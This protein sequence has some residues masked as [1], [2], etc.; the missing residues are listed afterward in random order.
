MDIFPPVKFDDENTIVNEDLNYNKMIRYKRERNRLL[1]DINKLKIILNIRAIQRSLYIRILLY[2][3][4]LV[5]R[6]FILD[7]ETGLEVFIPQELSMDCYPINYQFYDTLLN[8]A[9]ENVK[10]STKEFH[11]FKN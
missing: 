5:R 1:Y 3:I 8:S 9:Q 10:P 2:K 6:L 4:G 7:L 11:A